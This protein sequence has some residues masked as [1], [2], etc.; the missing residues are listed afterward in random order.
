MKRVNY[1]GM[2]MNP[3]AT[4]VDEVAAEIK[5]A[6]FLHMT[7]MESLHLQL[8]AQSHLSESPLSR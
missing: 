6:R 4:I 1:N 7:A 3:S 5:D 8:T 2:Q